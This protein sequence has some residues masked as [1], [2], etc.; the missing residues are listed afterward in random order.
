MYNTNSDIRFKTAML[1][2]NLCDYGDAYILVKEAVRIT[3]P[4]ND[5]AEGKQIKEIK[6]KYLKIVLH[7]LIVKV[8]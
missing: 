7:L 8:K 5:A 1:K 6:V 4:G 2:S 3:A